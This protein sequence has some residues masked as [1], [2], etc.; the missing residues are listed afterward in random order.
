MTAWG[1]KQRSPSTLAC[2]LPPAADIG[3]DPS[4]GFGCSTEQNI[5]E[6]DGLLDSLAAT[7]KETV[8]ANANVAKHVGHQRKKR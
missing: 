8:L 3:G 4:T 1:Q 6:R 7:A 5:S 2:R